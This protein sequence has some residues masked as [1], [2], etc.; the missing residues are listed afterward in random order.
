MS[1]RK[2]KPLRIGLFGNFGARNFG[3]ESTLQA[4]L[5]H[6]RHLV[7]DAELMCICNA[8]EV[9]AA[10]Y[11]IAAVPISAVV[12]K[13][14]TLRNPLARLLRKLFIGI[15][16]ELYRWLKGVMIL[17]ETDMLIVVG[18]GLLTD[19]FGIGSWGPY[20]IFKWSAISKLCGCRLLFASVGAGPLERPISRFLVRSALSLG[21]FRSYRD[22]GTRKYLKSIGVRCDQDPIFP[23]LAF[24][25]PTPSITDGNTRRAPRRMVGLGLMAHGGMYG[26]EKTTSEDYAAYMQVLVG[27]VRWLLNRGYDIRLLIGDG[28]DISAIHEFMSLLKV[29]S[30]ILQQERVIAEPIESSKDLMSQIAATDFV[31]G[32]RFHNVLLALFLKKPSI[33]IAFHPKCSS[34]MSQMGLSEYCQDIKQL[35]SN[36]LIEQFCQLEKNAANLT[37]MLRDKGEACRAALDQQYEVIIKGLGLNKEHSSAPQPESTVLTAPTI[38]DQSKLH[39]PR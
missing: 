15:P 12:V 6:L 10:D 3:N 25:L 23:D 17:R 16:S 7:P 34:L 31:V 36:D 38:V 1:K 30:E 2:P 4:M 29:R 39:L 13:P 22:E 24:G 35:N 5:H 33:A 37:Q 8:P 14:W 26:I 11:N 18:T 28:N 21:T 27:F 32:T 9:V 19:A 20:S